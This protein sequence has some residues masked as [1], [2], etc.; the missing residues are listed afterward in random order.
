MLYGINRS[1]PWYVDIVN[2]MVLG[3][4]PPEGNKK[5]LIQESRSHIR[6][7][8]YLFR[9]CSDGLQRRCVTIE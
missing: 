3:Y 9:V 7:E 4:V 1:D 2:L 5:K 6:D 8:P